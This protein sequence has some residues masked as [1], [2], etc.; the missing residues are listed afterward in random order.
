MQ[1]RPMDAIAVER[2]ARDR[3]FYEEAAEKMKDMFVYGVLPEIIGKRYTRKP[4]EDSSGVVQTHPEREQIIVEHTKD[5]EKLWCYCAQPS[6]GKMVCCDN[7][8]CTIQWFHSDCLR[9]RYPPKE[10]GTAHLA[11]CKCI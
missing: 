6:Y 11:S 3:E 1:C 7:S 10:N 5:P 9:I 2:I 8:T 4:V